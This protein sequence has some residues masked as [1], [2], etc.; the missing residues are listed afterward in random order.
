MPYSGHFSDSWRKLMEFSLGEHTMLNILFTII[1]DGEKEPNLGLLRI[2]I[3][4]TRGNAHYHT[5]ACC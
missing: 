2:R 5:C 4:V 3:P 1:S